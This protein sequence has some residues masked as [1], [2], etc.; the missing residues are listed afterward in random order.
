MT[1]TTDALERFG[2]W[3]DGDAWIVNDGSGYPASRYTPGP[4]GGGFY[5]RLDRGVWVGRAWR[6]TR[7]NL[8][9]KIDPSV[10]DRRVELAGQQA[11]IMGDL[12]SHY[13]LDPLVVAGWLIDGAEHGPARETALV[14]IDERTGLAVRDDERKALVA[15]RKRVEHGGS[16]TEL[17]D[18]RYRLEA[19]GFLLEW[20]DAHLRL[21]FEEGYQERTAR[22]RSREQA[23]EERLG[24][25][26]G[27]FRRR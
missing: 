6:M 15:L 9:T 24:Q 11:A 22:R 3:L 17:L 13:L 8:Q 12:D 20:P 2:A 1:K 14:D 7:S 10:W 25:K 19:L 5:E 21:S 26:R 23:R 27:L 4:N 18:I 16:R